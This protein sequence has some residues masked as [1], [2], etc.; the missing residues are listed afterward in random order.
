MAIDQQQT[1]AGFSQLPP[2]TNKAFSRLLNILGKVNPYADDLRPYLSPHYRSGDSSEYRAERWR[3]ILAKEQQSGTLNRLLN[4]IIRHLGKQR[5]RAS[6][7]IW[8]LFQF[9][10]QPVETIDPQAKAPDLEGALIRWETV[11]PGG[12]PKEDATQNDRAEKYLHGL[13]NSLLV[14]ESE[15]SRLITLLA[16]LRDRARSVFRLIGEPADGPAVLGTAFRVG[17]RLV[18]SNHHVLRYFADER[19]RRW[20]LERQLAEG[21]SATAL[22]VLEPPA[23]PRWVG[24]A[25]ADWAVVE[26][27]G[28]PDAAD[29]P[30]IRVDQANV[31][32]YYEG[33]NIVQYP[34]AEGL[35]FGFMRNRILGVDEPGKGC[36][37]TYLTDTDN[38]SSGSPVFDNAGLLIGMHAS[39]GD[40]IQRLN[41]GVAVGNAGVVLAHVL[42]GMRGQGIVFGEEGASLA[43][44]PT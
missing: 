36:R 24:D 20:R 26:I 37:F 41:Q 9:A 28:L 11:E 25:Q 44:P 21:T 13:V 31:P 34:G 3:E 17:P 16:I 30:V 2:A 27:E 6:N 23:R 42:E 15:L 7:D 4:E 10:T 35:K 33:A 12:Q 39:G 40:P 8:L 43:G 29:M 38:G 1:L 32:E 22:P 14:D 19:I 5:V 18:M